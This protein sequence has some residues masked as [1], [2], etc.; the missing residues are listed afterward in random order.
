MMDFS[1][2]RIHISHLT[3]SINQLEN[4]FDREHVVRKRS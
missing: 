2:A 4:V 3:K 1:H